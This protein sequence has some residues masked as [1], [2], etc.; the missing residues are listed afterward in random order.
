MKKNSKVY[1]VLTAFIALVAGFFLG[2]FASW[3]NFGNDD[4]MG[5]IGRADRYRNVQMTENDIMLRNE[6]L[7]DDEK[8]EQ[9]KNYLNY[10]YF[11]VMRTRTEL[12]RA[13]ATART[14][15]EFGGT[16]S[17]YADNIDG[18]NTY[19]DVARTDILRAIELV[20][21]LSEHPRVPVVEYLNQANNVIARLRQFDPVMVDLMIAIE[22]F[23]DTH[24]DQDFPGL[25]DAH[26]LLALNLMESALITQNR[27][28]L[29]FLDKKTLV[30]EKEGVAELMSNESYINSFRD[31][32]N[33]DVEKL[34]GSSS[35][36]LIEI[37]HAI[38][39]NDMEKMGVFFSTASQTLD[40]VNSAEAL[41]LIVIL[42]SEKINLWSKQQLGTGFTDVEKLGQQLF[43]SGW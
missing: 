15:P 24:P 39:M 12:E 9:Y 43:F 1:Y 25:A 14:V 7:G 37:G 35:L 23:L 38:D 34:G 21:N 3:P 11:K 2:S 31:Q 29:K 19:L 41:D 20:V 10:Y 8:Q 17:E 5:T 6:L 30:N 4:L 33:M 18:F 26:D 40:A 16:F 28:M 13:T 22:T 36:G 42:N 27:P 32:Y